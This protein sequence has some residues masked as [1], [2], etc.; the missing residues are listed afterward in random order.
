MEATC[1]TRD[2][3]IMRYKPEWT[4]SLFTMVVPKFRYSE[5]N[6]FKTPCG[7]CLAD[8]DLDSMHRIFTDKV[9]VYSMQGFPRY[10]KESPNPPQH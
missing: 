8:T 7:I 3:T 6:K 9:Y 2:A 10:N 5:S 1:F 4:L